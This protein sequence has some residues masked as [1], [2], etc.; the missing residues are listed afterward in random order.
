MPNIALMT[1][2]IS[3]DCLPLHSECTRC[4]GPWKCLKRSRF[5]CLV[6]KPTWRCCSKVLD[7]ICAAKNRVCRDFLH[8]INVGLKIAENSVKKSKKICKEAQ[9]RLKDAEDTVKSSRRKLSIATGKYD[10]ALKKYRPV[11]SAFTSIGPAGAIDIKAVSFDADLATAA[12]GK[13]KVSVTAT[14]LWF[15]EKTVSLDLNLRDVSS[16]AIIL[17]ELFIPIPGV[18][19]FIGIIG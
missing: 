10:S 8:K 4:R 1:T 15:F 13:F 9:V 7:K 12:T 11:V 19:T 6:W 16:F 2:I 5:R 14:T 18:G 3:N 17:A